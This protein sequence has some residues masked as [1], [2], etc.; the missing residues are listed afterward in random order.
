MCGWTHNGPVGPRWTGR[1]SRQ[2]AGGAGRAPCKDPV[3]SGAPLF[4]SCFQRP[5]LPTGLNKC[6]DRVSGWCGYMACWLP[7]YPCRCP[8]RTVQYPVPSKASFCSSHCMHGA[9]LLF[10][11]HALMYSWSYIR[12]R[13]RAE[14]PVASC[15]AQPRDRTQQAVLCPRSMVHRTDIVWSSAAHAVGFMSL[16]LWHGSG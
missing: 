7:A 8:A 14:Y 9:A 1:G 5:E 13:M 3:G 4:L 15:L 11:C 16:D 12:V 6:W 10:L 2:A